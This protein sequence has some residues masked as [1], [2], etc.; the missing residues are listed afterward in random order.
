M[1]LNVIPIINENDT[2]STEE[3]RFGDNDKLSAMIANAL[4]AELLIY[5]LM[6]MD[7]TLQNPK[8]SLD[9]KLLTSC[10]RD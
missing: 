3:I 5:F 1:D 8:K 2:T 9:A 7:S 10:S 6:S 4:S